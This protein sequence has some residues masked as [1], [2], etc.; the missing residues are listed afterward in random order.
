[1][2]NLSFNN[3]GSTPTFSVGNTSV[4]G[5]TTPVAKAL[6][7]AVVPKSSATPFNGGATPN[8]LFSGSTPPPAPT[9]PIASQVHTDASGN[10]VKTTYQPPTTSGLIN[11]GSIDNSG[12]TANPNAN[13]NA[14]IIQSNTGAGTPLPTT[15]TA[16]GSGTNPGISSP[17]LAAIQALT[18]ASNQSA[19]NISETNNEIANLR[20]DLA[21][22][23]GDLTNQGGEL[24]YQTG[25]IGAL[26]TLEAAK[27]SAAQSKLS[28]E[29]TAQGQKITGLTS[30]ASALAPSNTFIQQPYNSQLLDSTGQPVQGSGG[31]LDT[32]VQNAISQIKNGSGYANAAATL[33][34]YGPA[35][36]NALL[37]ALGPTFNINSSNA[38]AAAA[39]SNIG[40]Q[41][42]LNTQIGAQGAQTATQNYIA[43]NTA[44]QTA[45]SQSQNLVNTLTST[46]INNNPQFVNQKVN[47]LQNQLGSANYASFITA[48]NETK[49]AY[50]NLLSSVGASTPTVNGQQAT[51][52]FNEN[53]TPA[54]INAA[55]TALNAAAYAKLQPLYD[56]IGTYSNIGSSSNSNANSN[57]VYSF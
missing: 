55:I 6:N 24:S 11:S 28:N 17:Y 36:T 16:T 5:S 50:T 32:A 13:Y 10:S 27:E 47:A 34:A 53:S 37:S 42:T 8:G 30:A 20:N 44:Y 35:G 43:A 4:S 46:G 38:Q 9:Q 56:Q 12:G 45:S 57:S 15:N 26:N 41:G 1:M 21:S 25:R 39:A 22:K 33:S 7:A 52:I 40:T 3:Q 18:D 51:D 49:Q 19:P 31:S 29:L 54:Q 14:G 23:T 48:L 2:A